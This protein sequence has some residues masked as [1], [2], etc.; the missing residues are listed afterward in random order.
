MDRADPATSGLEVYEVGG[1]VRDDLLGLEVGERDWV[2]VGSTPEDLAA[3]GFRP[4]GQDFPVFL[5]PDTG[6]EYALARTERKTAPGYR[7]FTFHAG[8]DVGLED[9]LQRRDLTINAIARAADGRIIDPYGG[10]KDLESRRLRHVSPAFR[11]DP[12]RLLRLA[13]FATRF[14]EFSIAEETLELCR[15]MVAS[16]ETDHLVAERVW[17]EL[18]RALMH[19]RPSRFLQVLRSAGALERILPEVDQLYGVPQ[20]ATHHPEIDTGIHT[21]MVIDQAARLNAP[22]SARFAALVHDL[23]KALTPDHRL[24]SHPGHEKAGLKPVDRLCQ[25]LKVPRA[26]HDMGRLVCQWHLHAHRALELKPTTVVKLLEA[27]DVFRRPD[28]LEPFLIAC[29]ADARGR[30]GLEDRDYPQSDFIRQA[31]AAARDVDARS[32]VDRGLEGPAIAEAI[33]TARVGAVRSVAT[34]DA[35]QADRKP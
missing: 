8:S 28:R 33:R 27:L 22:L 21:E 30:T 14:S 26:C 10:R 29:E 20:P 13:R 15:A 32:F 18:S 3:R 34:T 6:E 17:Q 5:H 16:G 7:G 12:V 11:E 4:V 35:G 1:A 2:V 23:G 31:F 9:D 25:R 19:E 24:P